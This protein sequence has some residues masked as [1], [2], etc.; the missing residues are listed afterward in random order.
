MSVL[1]FK[2]QV[3]YLTLCNLANV[4]MPFYLGLLVL[5]LLFIIVFM[6]MFLSHRHQSIDMYY[7]VIDWF[8][9]EGNI[10]MKKVKVGMTL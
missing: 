2:T 10:A 1:I 9:Q 4:H 5:V 8:L 3:I 6:A 7:K